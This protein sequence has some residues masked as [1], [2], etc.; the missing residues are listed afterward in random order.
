MNPDL[1][2]ALAPPLVPS[3]VLLPLGAAV[4]LSLFGDLTLYAVLVTQLDAVL[5]HQ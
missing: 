3:R 1:E 2:G 4:C 5:F